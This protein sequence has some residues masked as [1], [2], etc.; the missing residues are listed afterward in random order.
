MTKL[1]L[2]HSEDDLR[3]CSTILSD[4]TEGLSDLV[5]AMAGNRDY[6]ALA[7]KESQLLSKKGISMGIKLEGPV[8]LFTDKKINDSGL[9]SISG[10]VDGAYS[11]FR[12]LDF[13]KHLE[14]TCNKMLDYFENPSE[15]ISPLP[16]SKGGSS[17]AIN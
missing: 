8:V 3:H 1:K 10:H 14:S 11:G 6:E 5:V 4:A 9:K 13:I 7:N 15:S 17:E 12:A 16:K 2:S